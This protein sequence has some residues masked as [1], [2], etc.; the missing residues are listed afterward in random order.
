MRKG[1][2]IENADRSQIIR[3]RIK[4]A[5]K[6]KTGFWIIQR[7][8]VG[9]VTIRRSYLFERSLA[10]EVPKVKSLIRARYEI[11]QKD[12]ANAFLRSL[13]IGS[14]WSKLTEERLNNGRV[15]IAASVDGQAVGYIWISFDAEKDKKLGI[16]V[17]PKADESYGFD[18]YVKPEYRRYMIGFGLIAAW[19]RYSKE[20]GKKRAIGVVANFNK[21][22]LMAMRLGFGFRRTRIYHSVEFLRWRGILLSKKKVN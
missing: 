1:S 4:D 19:L 15:G 20:M 11:G 3:N 22:M 16:R 18:L 14:L 7:A 13:G 6:R 8:I 21:P 5:G 2:E 9:I 10:E 12:S 17:D